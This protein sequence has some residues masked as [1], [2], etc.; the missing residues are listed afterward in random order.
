MLHVGS[1]YRYQLDTEF[2]FPSGS[3]LYLPGDTLATLMVSL[4]FGCRHFKC[5]CG[6]SI[7]VC[8]R[9]KP[10]DRPRRWGLIPLCWSGLKQ[11]SECTHLIWAPKGLMGNCQCLINFQTPSPCSHLKRCGRQNGKDQPPL[12]PWSQKWLVT[13]QHN[14]LWGTRH[15]NSDLGFM[16]WPIPIFILR[17]ETGAPTV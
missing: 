6:P 16:N 17:D 14:S 4:S 2:Q 11:R 9:L 13:G 3:S 10:T 1:I 12:E 8:T 15:A 7:A 5:A